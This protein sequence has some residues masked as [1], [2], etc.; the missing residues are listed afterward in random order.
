M[1]N[2]IPAIINFFIQFPPALAAILMAMFPVVER[3]ALPVAITVFK[4]PSW[5]ALILV[6]VGNMVPV[7]VILALAEQFHAWLSKNEGVFG[8]TWVKSLAHAQKKF[9]RYEK[10]GLAGLMIFLAIPTPLN[11]AFTAS[12][13]AFVLG[14][15]L[16][17][18][19]P[20]MFVGIVFAN[21]IVLL[22]TVGLDKVF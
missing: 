8:R 14:F 15:R 11:G 6:I 1:L 3:V 17:H 10:Y 7:I 16:R 9:A 13:I 2:M 5:E 18:A 21:V 4:L 12:L 22:A 20:Y 19:L